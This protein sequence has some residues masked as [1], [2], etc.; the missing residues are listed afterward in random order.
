LIQSIELAVTG[1][2]K[3]LSMSWGLDQR[4][5]FLEEA[6]DA[7][8]GSGVLISGA[9]GNEPTGEP[10]YPAAYDSV[11]AV[12]A[13][14]PDGSLWGNS[15]QGDFVS[16]YAPGFAL[17]PIGYD[18]KPGNYAGT[19]IATAYAA[20]RA[21]ITLSQNPNATKEEILKMLSE[22]AEASRLEEQNSQN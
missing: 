16:V 2:A 1:K 18:G 8:Y 10:V 4:S 11:M 3:V 22:T 19:S 12:G 14:N 21:V 5:L 20:H 15:N 17:L 7:A 6:L 9:A 13:V